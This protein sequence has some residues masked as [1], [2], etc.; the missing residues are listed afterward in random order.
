MVQ[1]HLQCISEDL[2]FQEL[3]S[4]EH[5]SAILQLGPYQNGFCLS[6]VKGHSFYLLQETS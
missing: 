1:T 5:S 2:I 4:H 6:D 3:N